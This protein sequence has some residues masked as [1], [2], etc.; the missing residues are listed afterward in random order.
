MKKIH[1]L[2]A[3]ALMVATSLSL[4]SCSKDDDSLPQV[5]HL[6]NIEMP[7]NIEN[8][9]LTDV[10]ITMTNVQTGKE[11][12]KAKTATAGLPMKGNVYTDTTTVEQGNYNIVVKGRISYQVDGTEVDS[13]VKA[14]QNNVSVMSGTTQ[15]SSKLAL[16]IYNAKQG[17][18]LSEIF[19]TGTLTPEGKQYSDD[20]YFKV[21]N[22]SDEVQYLDGVAFVESEFLTTNKQDYTPNLME[23]AMTI[24]AIY[25]FPGSGTEYPIEPGKEILVAINAKNHKEFNSNSFDLSNADFEIYDESDNPNF[26]DEQNP[27]VPDLINWYD[28]SA[29]Y[30]GM[31]NRGF[32]AYALAKPECTADEFINNFKYTYTYVFTF[33]EYSFDMDGEAYKLPNNWILDAVNLSVEDSYQWNV[34][35]ATLDAGW[36]HCGTVDMD[37]TRYGKSV[38]RKKNGTK[39]VDTNNSTNDFESDA[40]A[41]LL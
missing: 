10:S 33:G 8:G 40:K 27:N 32:K 19:F 36:A 23:S 16:N 17:L 29:S 2:A 4:T 5:A 38:I 21:A 11:Y 39:W 7:L 12:N 1:I 26:V 41:S 9:K 24:D 20:Q 37:K 22:N 30:F 15:S 25:V 28:Y 13:D 31:H 3:L 34:T 6:V 35:S 14:E 18:V